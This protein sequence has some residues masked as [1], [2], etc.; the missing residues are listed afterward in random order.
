M[1]LAFLGNPGT[2]KTTVARLFAR[3]LKKKGI[4]KKEDILEVS[5]KNLVAKFV[6][7]TAPLVASVFEKAKGGVLF[8]D[9]A[10]ALVDDRRGSFSDEAVNEIIAQMENHRD[11]VI[12]IFAGYT[13]KM[14]EFFNL[15]EGFRSRISYILEF[16]DYTSDELLQI[17]EK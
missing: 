12:V 17:F 16:E 2:A 3:I 10:Y 6:G 7:H 4:I 9:E 1:H 15:N 11:D 13:D 14:K 5:R 8:I